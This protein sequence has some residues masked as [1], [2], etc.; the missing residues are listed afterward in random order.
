MTAWLY[1]EASHALPVGEE[2]AHVLRQK[3]YRGPLELLPYGIDETVATS[4]RGRDS[5]S[6]G[7]REGSLVFGYLGRFV[8]DDLPLGFRRVVTRPPRT[9]GAQGT[10]APS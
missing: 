9:D 7:G 4:G 1:R 5:G 2:A 8:D 6:S 3:G 10:W